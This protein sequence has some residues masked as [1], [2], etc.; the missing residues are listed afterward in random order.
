MYHVSILVGS[1]LLEALVENLPLVLCQR[2]E[3]IVIVLEVQV[4]ELDLIHTLFSFR[5]S[6]RNPNEL[7]L[8]RDLLV[9]FVFESAKAHLIHIDYNKLAG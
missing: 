3:L 2:A 6:Y 8:L 1:C 9:I 7:T 4:C 5:G